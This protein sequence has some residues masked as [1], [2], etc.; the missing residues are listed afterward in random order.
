MLEEPNLYKTFIILA[1]PVFFANLLTSVH[2]IIDAYFLG[3]I[4]NSVSSQAAVSLSWPILNIFLS[5][6]MGLAVAGVSIISQ[7]MG[8]DRKED[9]DNYAGLLFTLSIVVGVVINALLYAFAPFVISH[10]GAVGAVYDCCIIYIRVRSFEMPFLLMFGAF[11]AIKQATGDMAAPFYISGASVVLNILLTAY[12]VEGLNWGIFGAAFATLIA[13]VALSPI[14]LYLL[15]KKNAHIRITKKSLHWDLSKIKLLFNI[16]RPSALGQSISSFGFLVLNS[17]I[18]S[19]GEAVVA[20][21]SN[22]NKISGIL[23]M[24]IGAIGTVQATYMGQN[25]GASNS[26]RIMEGY[27]TGKR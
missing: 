20:A 11:Q 26:H 12:F 1:T 22:G 5:L 6:S 27:R 3:Q 16:G 17:M 23:L 13:Q 8:A 14:V 7:N 4:Q 25:I 15:F 10:M 18:L 21:F 9:A 19:Y 24:P 2:D